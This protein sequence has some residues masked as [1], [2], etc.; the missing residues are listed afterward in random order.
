MPDETAVLEQPKRRGRPPKVAAPPAELDPL[1]IDRL[2][3]EYLG[4]PE[5][6]LI[7]QNG[8]YARV[9]EQYRDRLAQTLAWEQHTPCPSCHGRPGYNPL[10]GVRIRSWNA[11]TRSFVEGHKASCDTLAQKR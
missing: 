4:K 7:R 11:G 8:T 10:T 1:T 5:L 2:L 6:E 9:V 3:T